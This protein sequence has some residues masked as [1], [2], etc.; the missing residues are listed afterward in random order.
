[1]QHLH[2]ICYGWD[3]VHR[4]LCV[5]HCATR[6]TWRF[7]SLQLYGCRYIYIYVHTHTHTHTHTC[8]HLKKKGKCNR[9]SNK[10]TGWTVRGSDLGR[11]TNFSLLQSVQTGC[12]THLAS[13]LVRAGFF[14]RRKA[15]GRYVYHSPHLAPRL[16]I[17]VALLL[18]PPP[19]PICFH[20]VDS[21]EFNFMCLNNFEL[22]GC[23]LKDKLWMFHFYHLSKI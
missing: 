20:G 16:S 17:S 1:M 8:T 9:Y 18:P 5:T 14:L 7:S 4:I 12:G 22:R 11:K 15:D 23:R 10:A 13:C 2:Q 21:D 6:T 3:F 19:P